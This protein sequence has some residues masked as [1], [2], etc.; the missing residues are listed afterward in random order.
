MEEK[1]DLPLWTG[2][3]GYALRATGENG[4]WL[5]GPE[6]FTLEDLQVPLLVQWSSYLGIHHSPLEGLLKRTMLGLTSRVPDLGWGGGCKVWSGAEEFAFL[7]PV[8]LICWSTDHTLRTTV[9]VK[10]QSFQPANP[11]SL[12]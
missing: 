3:F 8:V 2:S 12:S 10:L 11:H 4:C 6:T 1:G 5:P 7:V 9:Q